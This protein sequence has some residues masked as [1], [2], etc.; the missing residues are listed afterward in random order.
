MDVIFNRVDDDCRTF[1]G[2][3]NGGHV[4]VEVFANRILKKGFTMFCA[5]HKMNAET[6]E[7]LG[8]RFKSPFQGWWGV[9][10]YF[11]RAMP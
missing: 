3:Q 8:H 9:G 5:E 6:C 10:G 1:H 7:R 2:F 4:C 11:P